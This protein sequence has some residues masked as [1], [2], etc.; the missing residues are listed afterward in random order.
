MSEMLANHYFH[1]REYAHARAGYEQELAAHPENKGLRRRLIV[2]CLQTGAVREAFVHFARLVEED[3]DFIIHTDP[4]DDDCPC[5]EL[6]KETPEERSVD[7]SP[8]EFLRLGMLWLFCDAQQSCHFLTA[9][10]AAAPGDRDL[11]K[12]LTIIRPKCQPLI[13]LPAAH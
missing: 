1:A 12:V 13:N 7:G 11:E 4:E 9:C 8:E 5:P 6:I 3:V 2:C 10:L